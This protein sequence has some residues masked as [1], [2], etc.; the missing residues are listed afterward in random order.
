MNALK[1]VYLELSSK[2]LMSC[3]R[4]PRTIMKGTYAELDLSLNHIESIVKTKP[5]RISFLGNLGDPIYHSKFHT[6][7][8]I[9]DDHVQKF[10]VYTAGSGYSKTWWEAAYDH[11]INSRWVFSID[12]GPRT[13]GI[14]R[15]GLD[16]NSAFEAMK[17]GALR[18]EQVEWQY[19]IFDH[20]KDEVKECKKIAKDNNIKFNT[21]TSPI[22]D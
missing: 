7:M 16:Y 4:C 1:N 20:N 12:G 18:G 21:V 10:T 8:Y 6:I 22:S 9:M 14:Y 3:S 11:E 2:C 5:Q 15:V 17:L 19:I 13:A